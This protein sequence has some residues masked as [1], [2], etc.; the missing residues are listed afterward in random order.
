[1]MNDLK[2]ILN[3]E[4]IRNADNHTISNKPIPSIDLM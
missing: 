4:Q 1:M 3:A 2:K